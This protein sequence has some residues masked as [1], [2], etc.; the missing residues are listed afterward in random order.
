MP[1]KT[2]ALISG[3][4]I[5][6]IILFVVALRAGQQEEA[7]STAEQTDVAQQPQPT[8]P[9]NSVLSLSPNP[10]TVAP[11]TQGSVEVTIDPSDNAV[12]AVQLEIGYD[13]NVL[14]NVQVT[15]GPLFPNPV[16]LID[17]NDA[18]AGRYT[19]A[20]GITPSSQTIT[21]AGTVATITF[22]T[23]AA[24]VG[25][26]T[27][28][29]LLPTTLITARG[30]AESVLKS[31]TGTIITVGG[32]GQGASA[33]VTNTFPAGEVDPAVVQQPADAAAL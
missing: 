19:Y 10:L 14:S 21:S 1:R 3:L 32:S 30:V 26:D 12:T 6:T 2:L 33:P 31:S 17:K 22:T 25:T 20:V 5:V 18:Q 9:A 23:N 7:P 4:V 29:G 13:P 27:Q 16:I 15:A 11:G 28:L 8:V 24:A